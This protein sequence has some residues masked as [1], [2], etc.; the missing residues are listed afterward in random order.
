KDFTALMKGDIKLPTWSLD[1]IA[2]GMITKI[3][4][5]ENELKYG[6]FGIQAIDKNNP[7]N[8]FG[9]NSQGWYISTDG[10][11]T[12]RTVATAEGI[13]AE[14]IIGN[15]LIGLQL[16]SPGET[17]YFYVAG[18]NAEFVNTS[19]NRKVQISPDGVYGYNANGDIRFQM[20]RQLVTSAALGTSNSNVYLATDTGFEG[21]VVDRA[22]LPGDGQISSYTY[23][24]MRALIYR[25]PDVPNAYF[26]LYNGGEFR[27]T[28]ETTGE[29]RV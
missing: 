8:V 6:S 10:G 15:H 21:R 18:N 11:R 1:E 17:G 27:F 26:T 28:G 23:R 9:L 19:N 29:G 12:A 24:P 14:S 2:R 7:N 22:Q 25:F 5:S 3:H 20:D 16:T 4:A 13:L